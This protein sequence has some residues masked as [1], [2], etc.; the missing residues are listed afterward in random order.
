MTLFLSIL[1]PVL[2]LFCALALLGKR[3]PAFLGFLN[4]LVVE[5]KISKGHREEI[6]RIWY[7]VSK[8]IPRIHDPMVQI[9]GEAI[10]LCW[11]RYDSYFD[12]EVYANGT[13]QWF[14]RN[15]ITKE[16]DGTED[17]VFY[18]EIDDSILCKLRE[19]V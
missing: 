3:E 19:T 14:Y 12:I 2:S 7:M 10:Q 11:D 18:S 5:G 15:R 8:K 13:F 6:L 4:V 16:V 9:V 1:I 17:D